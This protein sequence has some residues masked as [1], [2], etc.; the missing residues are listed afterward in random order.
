MSEF[1]NSF[2]ERVANL[3]WVAGFFDGE[4]CIYYHPDRVKATVNGTE[5]RSP[6]IQVIVG[7]S[8]EDGKLLMEAFQQVYG[9]GKITMG[10]GSELTKKIPYMCRL[11]GKKAITFL[12]YI[13][14]YL[15][16]KQE[17]AQMVIAKGLEHFYGE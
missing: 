13:E 3:N 4:G 7:Q 8:G 12:E 15:V 5:Y 16:L 2:A 6:E 1:R 10:H 14:P 17:K 11:S 9:F